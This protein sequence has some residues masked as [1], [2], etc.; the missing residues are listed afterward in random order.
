MV[1]KSLTALLLLCVLLPCNTA[2][3]Q[4]R[5]ILSPR[6]S[7]VFAIDTN[8]VSISYSRPSMRGRVVMGD[9]VPWGRVW[10]T[11]ANQATHLRTTFDMVLGGSPVPPSI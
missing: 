4:D 10:R 11:G 5:K 9:L 3:A 6:D 1:Q 2:G 7:V 8:V